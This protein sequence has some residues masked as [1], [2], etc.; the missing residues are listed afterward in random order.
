MENIVIQST[1][2]NIVH[3]EELIYDVCA[4]NHV[5]KYYGVISVAVLQAVENAIIHGNHCDANKKVKVE[6]GNCKGGMFFEI[7]DE[8]AGFATEQYGGLPMEGEKGEG[9]FLMKT[10][11]DKIVYS[12]NG[13]R[14]R[15]EFKIDGIEV[16]ESEKRCSLLDNFFIPNLINA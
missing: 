2:D 14:V 6:W 7:K 4:S 15:L 10:L 11:A 12:E 9:I 8:G 16:S 1:K 5:E 13:S 3:A